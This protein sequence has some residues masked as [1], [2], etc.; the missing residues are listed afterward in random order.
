M[1]TSSSSSTAR[2]ASLRESRSWTWSTSATCRPTVSTGF[3]EL[4]GSWK[5]YA[6]SRP[7]AARRALA[8]ARRSSCPCSRTEPSI[9]ALRGSSPARLIDVTLLPQPDSPTMPT[10]SPAC[11]A[12]VRRGR[13]PSTTPVLGLEVTLRSSTASTGGASTTERGPGAA[14]RH[15]RLA[16]GSRASRRLSPNTLKDSARTM[17]AR[18]GS[19]AAHGARAANCCAVDE[20]GAEAGRRRLDAKAEERQH[21]LAEDRRRDGDG[22]LDQDHGGRVGQ[23]VPA[24]DPQVTGPVDDR[25]SHEVQGL[26]AAARRSAPRG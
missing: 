4:I 13:R 9:L 22:C 5:M 16:F 25:G 6:M 7:R 26:A 15:R 3:S 10:I 23:D 20:H 8:G 17:M 1:P 18:P 2:L 14:R 12:E 21:R 19:T 11:E 24:E